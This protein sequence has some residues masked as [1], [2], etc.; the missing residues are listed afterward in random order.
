MS[1]TIIEADAMR[2]AIALSALGLGSSSPNPPV[3]CVIL[4]A[5]GRRVGEGYHRRKGEPH[6]EAH[7][8]A[9]AG[10][11]AAGGT[12][13]VTL[14]PCNHF[15]RTLPCHQDLI[16]AG[17]VRVLIAVIDPTSRGDGGAARLRDAGLDVE[18]GVLTDEVVVV[19]GPWLA[20]L[21]SGRQ[22]PRVIWAYE[23]G[24]EGPRALSDDFIASAGLR[25][26]VDAA[27]LSDGRI[28]EG[29]SGVHGQGA[30]TLPDRVL[31]TEPDKTLSSLH[32]DGVRSLLIHG[33]GSLA[34]PF[35]ERGLIDQVSLLL[36]ATK[37]SGAPT[38][39]AGGTGALLPPNF[40]ILSLRA[41]TQARSSRPTSAELGHLPV[42]PRLSAV[43]I[44]DRCSR[45]PRA[46]RSAAATQ[47]P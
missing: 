20:A 23:A 33:D 7:A 17:I 31:S 19:L 38:F 26:G 28:E 47:E 22:R 24:P 30:F 2:R 13:V 35:V 27:L 43:Q 37:P 4:D 42:E 46:A 6:A 34:E 21:D 8:L 32:A 3:S 16:D 36:A 18:V 1:P 29:T 15:G 40:P 5:A 44:T 10:A 41:W 39:F 11:R 14:E 9:A 45:S 12:A 25:Y